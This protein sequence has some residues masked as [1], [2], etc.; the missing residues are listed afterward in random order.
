MVVD[1]A[2]VPDP[3][4]TSVKVESAGMPSGRRT[5]V[6]R[7]GMDPARA[8]RRLIMYWYSM[9]SGDGRKYGMSPPLLVSTESGSSYC[10]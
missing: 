6:D 4:C 5:V 3:A 9:E 8:L 1:T 2:C 10:R 7:F